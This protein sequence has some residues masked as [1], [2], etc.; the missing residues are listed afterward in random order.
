MDMKALAERLNRV[1]NKGSG[2]NIWFKYSE[3]DQSIRILPYKHQD[4]NMSFI[5]VYF[6]YDIAGHRSIA[7]PEKTLGEPCPICKLAEE[8]RT[9]GGRDNWEIFR[10]MQAK[11]RTYAPVIIRGKEA[12]GVKLWGFG[13]TIYESLLTTCMDEGDITDVAS[14]HDLNVKQIPV[15][16]PGNDTTYPKPICKVSFKQSPALSKKAELK[17]L[18]RLQNNSHSYHNLKSFPPVGKLFLYLGHEPAPENQILSLR[19]RRN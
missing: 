3:E 8:F 5:E 16:A 10:D 14:G 12:E 7:C 19:E 9:M 15:G 6:H 1:Q 11:L 18:H 2:K 13:K 4:E 17:K